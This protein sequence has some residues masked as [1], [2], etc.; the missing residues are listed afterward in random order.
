[1]L[2]LILGSDDIG[3]KD[4]TLEFVCREI[5]IIGDYRQSG[6]VRIKHFL[7]ICSILRSF[8]S[9]VILLDKLLESGDWIFVRLLL[10]CPLKA[11]MRGICD[12]IAMVKLLETVFNEKHDIQEVIFLC[13]LFF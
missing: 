13:L 6:D 2:T 3:R 10:R 4:A 5:T 11:L 9:F 12:S 8:V 1:M 7:S